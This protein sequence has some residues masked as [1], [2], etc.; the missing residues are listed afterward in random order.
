MFKQADT[1]NLKSVWVHD[2]GVTAMSNGIVKR[3]CQT[4]LS[5]GVVK[6]QCQTALS[7]DIVK[8]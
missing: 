2:R 3:L 5:N 8:R 6:R 7:D 1:K 4:T